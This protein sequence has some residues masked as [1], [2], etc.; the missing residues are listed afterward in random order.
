MA[1]TLP[2][3]QEA[4]LRQLLTILYNHQDRDAVIAAA[5]TAVVSLQQM[6]CFRPFLC[7]LTVAVACCDIKIEPK[8]EDVWFSRDDLEMRAAR[9]KVP[10]EYGWCQMCLLTKQILATATL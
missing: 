8:D 10:R 6:W 7:T 9:L 3:G 2:T 5:F 1:N 4:T